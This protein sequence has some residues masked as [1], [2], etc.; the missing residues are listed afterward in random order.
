[1][2]ESCDSRR[3]DA[4]RQTAPPTNR[5]RRQPGGPPRQGP[6]ARHGP[7]APSAGFGRR[8]R[9]GPGPSDQPD[10]PHGLIR[11]VPP[12][13]VHGLAAPRPPRRV[14]MTGCRPD[15]PAR[16]GG[17]GPSTR[18]PRPACVA[19][20]DAHE[21]DRLDPLPP[22]RGPGPLPRRAR[23]DP[24][25]A[26]R[27]W[28][29]ARRPRWSSTAPAAAATSTA[30]RPCRGGPEFSFTHGGD[31]VGVAVR[32]AG[33]PI[34]LDV[35][36]VRE[37]T[38]LDGMARHVCSPAELGAARPM[39]LDAFFTAW[40]RK[41]ALL[42]ATGDGICR[43]DVGDHP[44]TR[45]ASTTWTGDE[46]PGRPGVAARPAPGPRLPS[47]GRRPRRRR[48]ARWSSTTAG[49]LLGRRADASS[50]RGSANRSGRDVGGGGRMG[51]VAGARWVLHLDMDAFYASVEQLTRPTLAGPAGAGRRAR[52]AGRGGRG[53]LPGPGVRAPARRCRW[54]RPGGCA[55]RR[56]CCRPRFALY[57]ALSERVMAVLAAAAPV[58]EPVSLD[59]AFLEPPDLAGADRG[60]GRAVRRSS[61]GP[62]CGRPPG[63]RPRSA[64]A[65]ASSSPRSPPSWPNRTGCGWCRRPSSRRCSTRCRCARCGGSARWPRPGCAGSACTP[66]A[67]WP[68]WTCARPPTCWAARSAPSC[69]GWPAASTTGRWPPR[70]AAKQVSAETT[71]DTDLT[72]MADVHEAVARMTESAHRRLVRSGRA[73]RTVT[74]KVR[75]AAFTTATRS[76]T[77]GAGRAPISAS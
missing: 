6:R 40:T 7:A 64:P 62:R 3:S 52:P 4:H 71:F 76:E 26:R 57:Q 69:T 2:S 9:S 50:S 68:R 73:A 66:S 21:R 14:T 58:L 23:A 25:G 27:R 11:A 67:S 61:C 29:G 45:T 63:C 51:A 10:P 70:G 39:S 36:P 31:L 18:S 42:K 46:R 60:G 8:A 32:P 19:L 48:P 12:R 30:S 20:L 65:P 35:E 41:E 22:G 49:P 72:A 53:Q 16:C 75:N 1:M 47:R 38:D 24:A 5:L 37:L 28:S 15:D 74:V 34:G 43:A 13:R 44:R 55:R 59:E 33:G 54:G 77:A 56:W 17:P